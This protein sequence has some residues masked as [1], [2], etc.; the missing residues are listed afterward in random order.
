MLPM[1]S[2]DVS[3]AYLGGEEDDLET[4][5]GICLGMVGEKTWVTLNLPPAISIP[6]QQTN[7]I[8]ILQNTTDF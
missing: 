8:Q 6:V 4:E 5:R 1:S 7:N 3:T 2:P